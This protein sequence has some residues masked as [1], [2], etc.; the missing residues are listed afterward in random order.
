MAGTLVDVPNEEELTSIDNPLD[1]ED[2]IGEEITP[3][4]DIPEKYRGK[5][6]KDLVQMHQEAEKAIG[7]QGTE[8]G[9]LRKMID[10]QLKEELENRQP[11]PEPEPEEQVDWFADPDAALEQRL[12]NHPKIKQAEAEST[13]LKRQ[14]ALDTLGRKHTDMEELLQSEDFGQWVVSSPTRKRQ[15]VEANQRIDTETMDDL[16]ST[17]KELKAARS[18]AKTVD[19]AIQKEQVK[20]A[21]TGTARGTN[22]PARKKKYRASDIRNLRSKDPERYNQMADE[23]LLAYREGRVIR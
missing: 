7:R 19:K 21:S 23:F 14:A 2:N 1:E 18:E 3:E 10:E 15:F 17:Y 5:S 22:P 12:N 13:K 8:V 6:M 9:Q 11:T 20:A 4:D 16:F